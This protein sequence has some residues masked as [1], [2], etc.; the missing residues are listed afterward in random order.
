MAL[1]IQ[2]CGAFLLP[3]RVIESPDL[4]LYGSSLHKGTSYAPSTLRQMGEPHACLRPLCQDVL[5]THFNSTLYSKVAG[6]L[7][8]DSVF[9]LLSSPLH[10]SLAKEGQIPPISNTPTVLP[11]SLPPPAHRISPWPAGYGKILSDS[12]MLL[13]CSKTFFPLDFDH[14]KLVIFSQ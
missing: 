1:W 13:L 11:T 4:P 14:R 8:H 7:I 5:Q 9:L 2:S 10:P 6:L 3:S 12:F